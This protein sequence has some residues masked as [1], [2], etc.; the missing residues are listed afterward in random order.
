MTALVRIYGRFF[1]QFPVILI[2][3]SVHIVAHQWPE[4]FN[5]RRGEPVSPISVAFCPDHPFV[6]LRHFNGPCDVD[7][8]VFVQS[9]QVLI[10]EVFIFQQ[11]QVGMI[12][13]IFH[14]IVD[15]QESLNLAG[16]KQLFY[17]DIQR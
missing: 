3:K 8:K 1:S 16:I 10:Y 9:L 5:I 17:G 13:G 7:I 15:A 14:H 6:L 11:K 2:T 12:P 4:I